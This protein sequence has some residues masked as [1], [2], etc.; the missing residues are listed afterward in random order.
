MV[1]VHREPIPWGDLDVTIPTA[2]FASFSVLSFGLVIGLAFRAGPATLADFVA[3]CLTLA[4]FPGPLV[5]L[6]IWLF[7]L[8]LL[9][10]KVW[11]DGF[12]PAIG[13]VGGAGESYRFRGRFLG[14]TKWGE[15][16]SVTVFRTDTAQKPD[17][18]MIHFANGERLRVSCRGY[19]DHRAGVSEALLAAW[20]ERGGP[21]DEA[22]SSALPAHDPPWVEAPGRRGLFKPPSSP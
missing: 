20:K 17:V 18:L 13:A 22:I 3:I 2:M 8:R 5:A 12:R 14:K 7:R 4:V 21:I 10:G 9:P 15:V 19:R 11:T 1:V 6:G 16:T